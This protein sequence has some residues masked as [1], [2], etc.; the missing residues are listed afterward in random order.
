MTYR[1]VGSGVQNLN[2]YA[3]GE[4]G[5]GSWTVEHAQ[6]GSTRTDYND[7]RIMFGMDW[8]NRYRA[9]GYFELGVAFAREL[10]LAD[11]GKYSLDP[12]FVLATGLRF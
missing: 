7:Y 10:Y 9:S 1:P 12:G 11:G 5:G 2:L 3:R 8:R 6:I 4:Y